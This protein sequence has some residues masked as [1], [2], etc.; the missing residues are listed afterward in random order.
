MLSQSGE[1]TYYKSR[2]SKMTDDPQG[3]FFVN[4]ARITR[5]NAKGHKGRFPLEITV[6]EG[7]VAG[8]TFHIEVETEAALEQWVEALTRMTS[9]SS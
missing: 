8:R 3:S 5:P 1:V 7:G 2:P 6:V 9:P 4:G